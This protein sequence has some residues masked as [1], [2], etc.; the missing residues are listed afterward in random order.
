MLFF[1]LSMCLSMLAHAAVVEDGWMFRGLW[2][3]GFGLFGLFG[4]SVVVVI[5]GLVI[6]VICVLLIFVMCLL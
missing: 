4:V 1:Y 5:I 6:G 2:I 3:G